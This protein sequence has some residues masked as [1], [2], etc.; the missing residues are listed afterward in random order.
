M[1][2]IQPVSSWTGNGEVPGHDYPLEEG[3]NIAAI[4]LSSSSAP[5]EIVHTIYG[6][7]FMEELGRTRFVDQQASSLSSYAPVLRGE[8]T[9]T[10]YT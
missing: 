1:N 9:E 7:F 5:N 3:R 10:I 8:T 6:V 4:R 2:R